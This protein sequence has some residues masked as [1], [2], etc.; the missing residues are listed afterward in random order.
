MSQFK[1]SFTELGTGIKV[2]NAVSFSFSYRYTQRNPYQQNKQRLSSIIRFKPDLQNNNFK[3][4]LRLKHQFNYVWNRSESNHDLRAKI[5]VKYDKKKWAITPFA[6]GELF[7][8]MNHPTEKLSRVR[9]QAGIEYPFK[10]QWHKLAKKSI[11]IRYIFQ[12]ELNGKIPEAAHII[13]IGMNFSFKSNK[14]DLDKVE[15]KID[16]IPH[17]YRGF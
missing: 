10:K 7:Y 17:E 15:K 6:A 8:D 5:S 12:Q 1:S 4:S 11:E 9:G 3:L 16:K 13:A 2:H 14:K